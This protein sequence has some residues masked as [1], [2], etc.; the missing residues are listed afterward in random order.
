MSYGLGYG[1]EVWSAGGYYFWIP[2][3]QNQFLKILAK[4]EDFQTNEF[5]L[6]GGAILRLRIRW[7]P[8]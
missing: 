6:D 2:V 8:I 1:H 7:F 3:S 4:F 5:E